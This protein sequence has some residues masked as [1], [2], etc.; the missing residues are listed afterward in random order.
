MFS[1]WINKTKANGVWVH[2]NIAKF[3]FFSHIAFSLSDVS[4]LSENFDVKVSQNKQTILTTNNSLLYFRQCIR[5]W[6]RR[7]FRIVF[8]SKVNWMLYRWKKIYQL[9]CWEDIS[10]LKYFINTLNSCI[11]KMKRLFN[12]NEHTYRKQ[13]FTIRWAVPCCII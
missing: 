4:A 10:F 13:R 5:L 9:Y 12:N 8:V 7:I 2:K 6:E 11:A 3:S 1:W